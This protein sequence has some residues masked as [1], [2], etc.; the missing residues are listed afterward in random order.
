ML[1]CEH[2]DAAQFLAGRLNTEEEA[3]F[4]R[5]L[6][7]C[8][9]CRQAL[10]KRVGDESH[11]QFAGE[12]LGYSRELP[13]SSQTFA[14]INAAAEGA[15]VAG[16]AHDEGLAGD[17]SRRVDLS[18]LAPTDDPRMIGRV[19]AYEISAV[20]GVG[21]MGI[22]LKGFDRPLNRNVAV[23]VL[24]PVL[25][26]HGAARRRFALEAR[27]MAAVS[28]EQVVAIYAVDE[29]A[30]LPYFVMEY[31]PG[32][33]LE[34]RLATEG[35]LGVVEILRVGMQVARG[36][37]A[38]HRQGLVHR[39]IKPSNI[40][41]DRGIERVRVADFGL[42]RVQNEAGH[43]RTGLVVG[44]PQYM[45][46][47]QIRGE[48][49]DARSDLFSL[50]CVL[51]ALCTGH[52][53]F[54]AESIYA[55]MHRIA[56]DDPRSIREQNP[57]VP[58]WL[59][60][61]VGRLLEKESRFRFQTADELAEALEQELAYL[62]NPLGAREP[63]RAW[64]P[65][66]RRKNPVDEELASGASAAAENAD[67]ST[68]EEQKP[69]FSNR[70]RILTMTALSLLGISV[71]SF[72]L[73]QL[74]DS[75]A[76]GS[77]GDDS[78]SRQLAAAQPGE[79]QLAQ[80]QGL[81]QS[82]TQISAVVKSVDTDTNTVTVGDR[83]ADKTFS[84]APGAE[85]VINGRPSTLARLHPGVRI[86]LGAFTDARTARKL[87]AVGPNVSGFVKQ[88]DAERRTIT[89][90]DRD[91]EG[92]YG[93]TKNG[94]ISIDN[95]P[96]SLADIPADAYVTLGWFA[97]LKTCR[98]VNVSGPALRG[99][100]VKAVDLDK[101][102]VT[103]NEEGQPTE[104]SGRAF[105]V[106]KDVNVHIDGKPGKVSSLAPGAL[107]D[108]VISADRKSIVS[109]NVAGPAFQGVVVKSVNA[110]GSTITID[111][112]RQPPEVA[113]KTLAVAR[114]AAVTID[115]QPGTLAALPA[116]A[117][118]NLTLSVDRTTIRE[119]GANGP[120]F[121]SVPVKSVDV[122]NG[123]ITC[124]SDRQPAEVA[125]KTFRVTKNFRIKIDGKPGKLAD[126]A[127]G[128]FM[129][130]NLTADLKGFTQVEAQGPDLQNV[131]VKSVDAQSNS[132]TL[133]ERDTNS[134]VAGK[135]LPVA[136]DA[137]IWL[138]DAPGR[139]KDVP[140]GIAVNLTLSTDRKT[141]RAIN[142]RGS[143]IGNFGGAVVVQIDATNNTIT[144]DINGEGERV[145]PVGRD[146][147]I[148]IDGKPAKLSQVP[149]E[150]QVILDLSLDQKTVRGIQ[151]KAP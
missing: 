59:E 133:D 63:L 149:G 12:V 74:G 134:L 84:L 138:D 71:L 37:A 129:N 109:M 31:A 17:D 19:G 105:H 18:F 68:A 10:E 48:P 34:K 61:L 65:C 117:R 51:Y 124:E 45:S 73:W 43:T 83:E 16:L 6:D 39:D 114:D 13:D 29:H 123:T 101:G 50:G 148:S 66:E 110:E 85:I 57:A 67:V 119:I 106:A 136:G 98:N 103:F 15:P 55:V 111:S 35:S 82:E 46:P 112:D 78:S 81:G 142:A 79:T 30:T 145:F 131:L 120:G 93:V 40:L 75:D 130:V 28:H 64:Q 14:G 7:E 132:L 33:T 104:V 1:I 139:V 144:I 96:G 8:S 151:A 4:V 90:T 89:L 121:F 21:A 147:R 25:A 91:F 94:N 47:E 20:I 41:L 56:H 125:G 140:P 116:G 27:A 60:A 36:L 5:H 99:L 62:Q 11:W 9:H 127:A 88:V 135:T 77:S 70:R 100:V 49:C 24:H 87:T 32:G 52:P 128:A 58:R 107:A 122:E 54:R 22:V 72:S 150:A 2:N 143:Q 80:A 76:P 86:A 141:I 38:A 3:L 26:H 115:D 146:A 42:A 95:K 113:G 118:V 102:T 23:K 69:R 44:T 53:P 137:F 126:L 97:D 92:T 108:V